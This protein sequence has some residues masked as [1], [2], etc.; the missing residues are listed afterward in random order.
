[1]YAILDVANDNKLNNVQ[2]EIT[3][4]IQVQLV[5]S[6]ARIASQSRKYR[7][8]YQPLTAQRPSHP[9]EKADSFLKMLSKIHFN[10]SLPRDTVLSPPK[11]SNPSSLMCSKHIKGHLK[12]HMAT[13]ESLY[14]GFPFAKYIYL[15]PDGHKDGV[16]LDLDYPHHA[17]PL[18]LVRAPDTLH[19]PRIGTTFG[20]HFVPVFRKKHMSKRLATDAF[21]PKITEV[22]LSHS[23]KANIKLENIVSYL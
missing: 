13:S 11:N 5:W 18:L 6:I 8:V 14:G 15:H 7:F 9:A 20:G 16:L 12:Y 3:E 10:T 17:D 23:I 19:I 1:M 22:P 21:G 2:A 4:K